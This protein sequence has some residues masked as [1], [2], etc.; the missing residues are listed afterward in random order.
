MMALV[1][2]YDEK[3]VKFAEPVAIPNVRKVASAFNVNVSG[4]NLTV[5][6]P[7][8]SRGKVNAQTVRV[9]D[10][11]GSQVVSVPVSGSRVNVRLPQ[12]MNGVYMVQVPGL[13]VRKI[14]VR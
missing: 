8:D 2:R 11:L 3:P 6:L 7:T 12:G 5:S 4:I 10:L 14:V 13:G 9:L 1:A